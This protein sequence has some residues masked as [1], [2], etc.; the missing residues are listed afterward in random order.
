MRRAFTASDG[1]TLVGDGYGD[2]ARPPVLLMHGGGQTR[3]AWGGTARA[4]A[5][6]G[7]YALC[8][9]LRGH[10]DS[11]W[12]PDGNYSI[13]VF[14]RDLVTI[15]RA[16]DRPPALVGAS[17]SG[18]AA[19]IAQGEAETGVFSALVLVDVTPRLDPEGTQH[20]I[21][22]MNARLDDG[23]ASLEEAADTIA[24]YVPH[25]TRPKTLDGLAKNLRRHPDG[26][27]R[28]HWDPQFMSG[29]RPPD[30]H[31]QHDRLF[32]AARALRIPTLLVR[33]RMSNLVTMEAAEEFLALAPHAR[34]ADVSGAGHMVAG[35][36]N[37]AFTAAVVEFLAAATSREP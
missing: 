19:L 34:F 37:D 32:A 23:F 36:R 25:R 2:P 15:A 10:G 21:Q 16:F 1:I 13:D 8:V 12:S 9:D 28:W 30:V 6:G 17:L 31:S 27:Y 29:K 24:A 5:Q 20:I 35:D 14:A 3:H 11:G 33:G 7:W 26:R 4:L 22:F 18:L